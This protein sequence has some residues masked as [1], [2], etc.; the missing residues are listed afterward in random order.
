M[1]GN[2][3]PMLVEPG[4]AHVYDFSRNVVPGE[5]ERDRGYWRDVGTLDAYFDA[6]MDLISVHPIFNLYNH[7]WPI[8][9]L[10]GAAAAGEVRLRRGRPP[11]HA[12]DSMVCA[13]VVHLGRDGAPLRALAGRAPALLRARSR[14]RC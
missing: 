10:A 6:H 1:G 7:E 11:G 12:L 8:L 2:I 3:V 9:T 14:T 13:G 4:A 5:T